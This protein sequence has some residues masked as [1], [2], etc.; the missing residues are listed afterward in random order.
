MFFQRVKGCCPVCGIALEYERDRAITRKEKGNNIAILNKFLEYKPELLFPKGSS[1]YIAQLSFAAQLVKAANKFLN[2]NSRFEMDRTEFVLCFIDYVLGSQKF[3]NYANKVDSLVML[4]GG[5]F[6]TKASV[7]LKEI[8]KD[9]KNDRVQEMHA[10]NISDIN[11]P[12]L[13]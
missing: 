4:N 2:Y 6:Y 9:C 1:A 5:F 7:V 8:D 12:V 3:T 11:V 13:G 10:Q